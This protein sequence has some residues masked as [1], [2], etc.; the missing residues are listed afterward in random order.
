MMTLR[1]HHYHVRES[2]LVSEL[3]ERV[4]RAIVKLASLIGIDS[5]HVRSEAPST[6][7]PYTS[8]GLPTT[9]KP[10]II[11]AMETT[12]VMRAR[13]F[14]ELSDKG[15][16]KRQ[17]SGDG[18]CLFHSMAMGLGRK[19]EGLI[20]R[21]EIIQ[22]LRRNRSV[23]EESILDWEGYIEKLQNVGWGGQNELAAAT[24]LYGREFE[25]WT[26]GTD[27][28]AII[29]PQYPIN[30]E[31]IKLAYTPG[32]HN[33]HYD[34]LQDGGSEEAVV[35]AG[36]CPIESILQDGS[37]D[38][39]PEDSGLGREIVAELGTSS[40]TTFTDTSVDIAVNTTSTPTLRV[41]FLN[42][43]GWNSLN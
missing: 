31:A 35:E 34:L 22:L 41:I 15:L 20:I 2:G 17:A 40:V 4:N 9:Q 18:F 1:N 11:M 39:T 25:I 7:G 21:D 42:S 3:D 29:H 37:E 26:V 30:R 43:K 36:E 12:P 19:D 24:A 14:R 13:F 32:V 23:Y 16:E 8:T 38:G 6:Q 33:A 5:H 27:G 28:S 10:G